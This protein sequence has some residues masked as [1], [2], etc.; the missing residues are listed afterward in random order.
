MESSSSIIPSPAQALD[1]VL[2]TR[3]QVNQWRRE[4]RYPRGRIGVFFGTGTALHFCEGV[5]PLEFDFYPLHAFPNGVL[6][7]ER[8]VTAYRAFLE[9]HP[10]LEVIF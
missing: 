2:I 8:G 9:L 5:S 10:N 7:F 3:A 4:S 1:C 6:L